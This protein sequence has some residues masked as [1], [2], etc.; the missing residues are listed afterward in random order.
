MNRKSSVVIE[1]CLATQILQ[2]LTYY[3]EGLM[4]A[5]HCGCD[6]KDQYYTLIKF[7]GGGAWKRRLRS[8]QEMTAKTAGRALKVWK[9]DEA[10]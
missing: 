10:T 7:E 6:R 2:G 3:I 5:E 8:Y 9:T 1:I 4:K